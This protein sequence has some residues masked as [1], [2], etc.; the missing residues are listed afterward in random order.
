MYIEGC[1][2]TDVNI[3]TEQLRSASDKNKQWE[4]LLLCFLRW[5][6]DTTVPD[7]IEALIRDKDRTREG[8]P[9]R[10]NGLLQLSLPSIVPISKQTFSPKE[11]GR[12]KEEEGEHYHDQE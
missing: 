3:T 7:A 9:K 8:P 4:T 2:S 10:V 6:L 12:L 5:A 11:E 1:L